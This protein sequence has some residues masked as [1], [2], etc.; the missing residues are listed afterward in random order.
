MR[1]PPLLKTNMLLSTL[2]A[3]VLVIGIACTSEPEAA[4][5]T[6][7]PPHRRSYGS[8]RNAGADRGDG[9][10]R[11]HDGDGARRGVRAYDG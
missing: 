10:H 7:E 9:T 1:F 6:T 5:P 11:G 8:G 4:P 3:L 2:L